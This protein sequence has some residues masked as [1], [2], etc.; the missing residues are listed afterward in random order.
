MVSPAR[1]NKN[2][3]CL[4]VKVNGDEKKPTLFVVN[5]TKTVVKWWNKC[6]KLPGI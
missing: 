3:C 6:L 2:G 4:K 5:R 1:H